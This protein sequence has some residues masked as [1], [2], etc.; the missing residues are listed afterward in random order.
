MICLNLDNEVNDIIKELGVDVIETPELDSDAK[1][2]AL[3]NTIVLD[4]R[5]SDKVKILRL[6]HEL[7]HAA[8]HKNNYVLYKKTFA[9][10]SKM[11]NEAEEFMIEKM[12][13]ATMKNPDF[14]PSSFNYLNFL[15]SYEIEVRYE[16]V[17]KD[18]MTKYLVGS[19][20]SKI[21]F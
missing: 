21:F 19:N 6:L 7:G 17:V 12:L 14:E 1:Y 8:Q 2:I 15:E 20:A 9:L 3:M 10:H 11:E 5:L 18:F 13:E 16:P 4:K